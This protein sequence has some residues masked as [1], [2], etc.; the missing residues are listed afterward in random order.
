MLDRASAELGGGGEGAAAAA[1]PA[2]SVTISAE[3]FP[4]LCMGVSVLTS[5]SLVKI[6]FDGLSEKEAQL[7]TD[8]LLKNA[9]AWDLTALIQNP[10]VAAGLDLGGAVVSILIPRIIADAKK[11]QAASSSPQP[12]PPAGHEAQP[13]AAA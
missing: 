12:G 13:A 6:G 10:R 9:V 7:L 8:A 5:L 3:S 4:G 1:S 11:R 2:P